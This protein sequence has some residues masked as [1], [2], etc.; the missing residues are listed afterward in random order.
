[1]RGKTA[2]YLSYFVHVITF[3]IY[4]ILIF[5]LDDPPAIKF[6]NVLGFVF[7]VLGVVFLVLSYVNHLNKTEQGGIFKSGVYG[8][9]RHPMYLG[10][11]FLF[12][13]MACFLP[14]W[15]MILLA[16]INVIL[17]YRFMLIEESNNFRKFGDAYHAYIIQVP[18]VN[19]VLGFYKWLKRRRKQQ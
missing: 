8:I 1:M 5:V 10:A 12:I 15:V 3:I 7:L 17:I 13:A 2:E 19:F 11:G 14:I 16:A 18:R 6:L 9:V 4:I